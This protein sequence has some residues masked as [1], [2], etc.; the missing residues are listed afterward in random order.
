MREPL[1]NLWR[2]LRT[3]LT[4]DRYSDKFSFEKDTFNAA[5]VA[6]YSISRRTLGAPQRSHQTPTK[7]RIMSTD[8]EHLL[9]HEWALA[10]GSVTSVTFWMLLVESDLHPEAEC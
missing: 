7:D 3:L 1:E 8:I 6:N 5:K 4:S 9:A 2:R 10:T